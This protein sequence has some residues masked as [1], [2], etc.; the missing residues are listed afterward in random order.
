[1]TTSLPTADP[2]CLFC[3]IIAGRIPA[4]IVERN[5]QAVAFRDV[6]PQSS[7]H[8]LVVPVHHFPDAAA[9][10]AVDP[11][12]VGEMVAMAARVAREEKVVEDGYR[13]VFNTGAGAGQTVFHAHLHL[14][15]GRPFGWPPG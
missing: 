4:A 7:T 5:D 12:L 8:V 15:G 11:A 9:V 2:D 13:L 10:A 3:N 6:N 1:M 14:L